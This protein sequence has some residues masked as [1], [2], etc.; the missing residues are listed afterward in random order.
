MIL[1]TT[2]EMLEQAQ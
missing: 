2:P 1:K